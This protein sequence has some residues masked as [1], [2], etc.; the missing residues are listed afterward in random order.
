M[1]LG[2]E[3]KTLA[4]LEALGD[5]STFRSALLGKDKGVDGLA[6]N[7]SGGISKQALKLLINALGTERQVG[8]N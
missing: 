5:P 4:A 7:F 8:K 2:F 3:G 1:A 6:Q